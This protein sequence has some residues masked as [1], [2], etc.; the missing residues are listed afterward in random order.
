MFEDEDEDEDRDDDRDDD[1][2]ELTD[3]KILKMMD[4]DG[5]VVSDSG[6]TSVKIMEKTS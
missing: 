3:T 5:E 4:K 2:K 1:G 6:F